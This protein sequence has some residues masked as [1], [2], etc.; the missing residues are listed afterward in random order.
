MFTKSIALLA[1]TLTLLAA[2]TGAADN[3]KPDTPT[4]V[5]G[6]TIISAERAKGFLDE[7]GVVFFDM[8]NP[9]NFGKGHL[10]GATLMPYKER[11]AFLP[12]FDA[13]LDT[14]DLA[15][16]PADKNARIVLYSD[17][18][19]GWKSY[20]AAVLAAQAGY[21]NVFW[22]RDGFAVWVSSGLPVEH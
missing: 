21:T 14:V 20:K 10:P 5:P 8:R 4:S 7:K 16:L 6:A 22:M 1:T 2:P 12:Q 9:L 17:G 3:P 15:R 18:P 19:K 11:S 13:T